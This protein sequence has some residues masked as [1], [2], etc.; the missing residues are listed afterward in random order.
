MNRTAV[1]AFAICEMSFRG[2]AHARA[3]NSQNTRAQ[4]TGASAA[5]VG[6]IDAFTAQSM[7]LFGLPAT[8]AI[9]MSEDGAIG[10]PRS[11]TV[12]TRLGIERPAGTDGWIVQS[13]GLLGL[14]RPRA[15]NAQTAEAGTNRAADANAERLGV[16]IATTGYQHGDDCHCHKTP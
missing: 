11:A 7:A 12:S 9:A 6:A 4:S 5:R 15:W 13:G 3:W 14:T 2:Y 1:D 16:R 10:A 8:E